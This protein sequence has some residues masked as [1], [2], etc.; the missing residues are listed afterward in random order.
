MNI[1]DAFARG[2]FVM[3]PLLILSFLSLS[4]IIERI[5]FWWRI[6]TR[7]REIA[8]RVLE[9]SRREWQAAAE[10]AKRST[11]QPIGRF[12]NSALDLRDPEP[13]V[14]KLALESAADE[15]L[16]AMQRGDKIL[17]ATIAIAP[18]LGLL[19]TVLGLINSLGSIRLGDIGTGATDEVS[20]GIAE[21][22]YST[23]TGLIVALISL[24]F[25]RVFQGLVSGQAKLFQK[26]GSELEL[27]YRQRWAQRHGANGSH[28]PLEATTT[29]VTPVSSEPSSDPS[30][31]TESST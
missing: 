29:D 16:A 8:G 18:L 17:E 4:V 23:A 13:E 1:A 6:L 21:A 14:L 3:I 26:S 30:L 10:I 25:F 19:G 5:W 22:L 24:V 28:T 2:G 12:L 31:T 11:D 27:L 20:F 15:E 9:A 7:E